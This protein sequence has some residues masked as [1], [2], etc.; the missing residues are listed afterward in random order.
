[1]EGIAAESLFGWAGE[2]KIA[3]AFRTVLII[4]VVLLSYYFSFEASFHGWNKFNI[5]A[6][7]CRVRTG[8]RFECSC[9]DLI[10]FSSFHDIDLLHFCIA[11][12]WVLFLQV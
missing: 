11:I 6:I 7:S 1:M 9:F 10:L 12:P 5:V 8:L 2:K 3:A 4:S